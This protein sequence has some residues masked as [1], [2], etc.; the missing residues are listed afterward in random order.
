MRAMAAQRWAAP[1]RCDADCCGRWNRITF[2]EAR[3][4]QVLLSPVRSNHVK[5]HAEGAQPLTTVEKLGLYQRRIAKEGVFNGL[6][7][8]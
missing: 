7:A 4:D 6:S 1:I 8:V 3:S 2:G 5:L